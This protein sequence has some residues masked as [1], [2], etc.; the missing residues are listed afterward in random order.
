MHVAKLG[1]L[2]DSIVHVPTYGR[3]RA[4]DIIF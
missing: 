3:P 2:P 1:G 4:A